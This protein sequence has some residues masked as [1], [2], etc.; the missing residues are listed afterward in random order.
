MIKGFCGFG[1][2]SLNSPLMKRFVFLIFRERLFLG[3]F[4][5]AEFNPSTNAPPRVVVRRRGTDDVAP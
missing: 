5:P 3:R 4:S 1:S 2:C